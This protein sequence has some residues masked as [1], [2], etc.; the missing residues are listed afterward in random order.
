MSR[1]I[2]SLVLEYGLIVV[3]RDVDQYFCHVFGILI[4][5][6]DGLDGFGSVTWLGGDI[7]SSFSDVF[8]KWRAFLLFES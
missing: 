6:W 5:V 7:H 3:L 4:V 8:L 2:R 1:G